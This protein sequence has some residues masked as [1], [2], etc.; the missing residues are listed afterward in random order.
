MVTNN[1]LWAATC[2]HVAGGAGVS[3]GTRMSSFAALAG[4]VRKP[5]SV[6]ARYEAQ[7]D[8]RAW[9]PPV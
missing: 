2:T 9:S 6:D 4:I 1:M 3:G 7:G 5:A 8:P